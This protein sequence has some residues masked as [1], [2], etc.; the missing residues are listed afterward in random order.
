MNLNETLVEGLRIRQFRLEIATTQ[1][2]GLTDLTRRVDDAVARA[3]VE[4]GQATIAVLHTTAGVLLNENE[5]RLLED[6]PQALEALVPTGRPYRHD[7]LEL[8]AGPL[9]PGERANGDAHLRAL[10]LGSFVVVPIVRGRL[11]LGRWQSVLLCELDGPR[12]RTIAV[13]VLGSR[14]AEQGTR[15]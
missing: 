11:L 2:V 8:R 1:R 14:A 10:L 12:V 15:P 7:D 6:I 13:T 4:D 5:P 9:P 3:E